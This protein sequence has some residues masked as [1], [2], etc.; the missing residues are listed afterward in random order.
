[1]I[2][3]DLIHFELVRINCT[4]WFIFFSLVSHIFYYCIKKRTIHIFVLIEKLRHFKK[5]IKYK[6]DAV[7]LFILK[8]IENE[9]SFTK[10]FDIVTWTQFGFL[11]LKVANLPIL[12]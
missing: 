3:C 4:G 12:K 8:T 11:A 10:L 7:K 9:P 6:M 5:L 2:N 1:M